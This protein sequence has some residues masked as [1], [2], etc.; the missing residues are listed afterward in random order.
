MVGVLKPGKTISP[1]KEAAA[2]LTAACVAHS[3]EVETTSKIVEL[4]KK[5]YSTIQVKSKLDFV[6]AILST[7]RIMDLQQEINTSQSVNEI[8]ESIRTEVK[9]RVDEEDISNNSIMAAFLAAACVSDSPEIESIRSIVILWQSINER[10]KIENDYDN[11]SALL[12]TGRIEEIKVPIRE[13][14]EVEE[15]YVVVKKEVDKIIKGKIEKVGNKELV[16]AFL[17]A[18]Y[19]SSSPK[20]ERIKDIVAAWMHV[21]YEVDIA[22]ESEIIA[23]ILTAGRIRDQD[24]KHMMAADSINEL[25]KKM[26]HSV[27]I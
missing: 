25:I 27:D 6:S 14:E 15:L 2:F 8:L 17:A 4:W 1:A 24:A 10:I 23:G 12:T 5:V 11:I 3:Y 16:S 7:G 26:K 9:H 21:Y 19:I 13:A 22:D 18:A 20:V